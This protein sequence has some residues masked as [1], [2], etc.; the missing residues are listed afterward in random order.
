MTT[1]RRNE[2][3]LSKDEWEAFAG[4]IDAI[5]KRGARKPTYDDFVKVHVEAMAGAGMHVWGVHSMAGMRGRNFL[6]WHRWYLLQF[7][8]RLQDEDPDVAVPYW[9][10]I[11]NPRI[12]RAINRSAQLRRWRIQRQWDPSFL[13]ERADLN[14]ALRRDKFGPFQLRLEGE[15]GNVH[16]AVGGQMATERSPADP[17]FWLHHANVDRLWARW[18]EEH[19][20]QRPGN[21]GEQLKPTALFGVKVS[22]TLKLSTLGYRY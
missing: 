1:V 17:L 7:E 9:D 16:I 5:R 19:P 22:E 14:R 8:R 13:P 2:A 10:W 12:P 20:R 15:H 4:A 21:S 6:A 18:Q 3:R 11:A